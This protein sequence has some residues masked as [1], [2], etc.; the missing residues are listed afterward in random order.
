MSAEKPL[1]NGVPPKEV[2]QNFGF[3][4]PSSLPSTA[5]FPLRPSFNILN[6]PFSEATLKS[7]TF[8]TAAINPTP[9]IRRHGRVL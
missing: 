8:N 4:V 1:A 9:Q 6:N 3:S 5:G 7:L 2:A